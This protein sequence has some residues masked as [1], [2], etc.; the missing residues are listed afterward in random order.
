MDDNKKS[1]GTESSANESNAPTSTV[2]TTLS[3][4]KRKFRSYAQKQRQEEQEQEKSEPQKDGDELEKVKS[5]PQK[6]EKAKEEPVA[7]VAVAVEAK[8]APKTRG[9][10]S[11]KQKQQEQLQQQQ[12]QAIAEKAIEIE[13]KTSDDDHEDNEENEDDGGGGGDDDG[14]GEKGATSIATRIKSMRRRS[15]RVS[16][17]TNYYAEMDKGAKEDLVEADEH[18]MDIDADVAKINQ[19]ENND[20]HDQEEDVVNEEDQSHDISESDEMMSEEEDDDDDED[21]SESESEGDQQVASSSL[22][23]KTKAG[24]VLKHGKELKSSLKKVPTKS[25]KDVLASPSV[26]KKAQFSRD[27]TTSAAQNTAMNKECAVSE[28]PSSSG[29]GAGGGEDACFLNPT[30]AAF[31]FGNLFYCNFCGFSANNT[32]KILHHLFIHVFKCNACSHFTYTKYD[33][34]KHI[35]KHHRPNK[36]L[37]IKRLVLEVTSNDWYFLCSENEPHS[38]NSASSQPN[39]SSAASTANNSLNEAPS[40]SA[41][42][43]EAAE[44]TQQQQPKQVKTAPQNVVANKNNTPGGG[45]TGRKPVVN[46]F[47]TQKQ[48]KQPEKLTPVIQSN[49]ALTGALSSQAPVTQVAAVDDEAKGDEAKGDAGGSS[50]LQKLMQKE[51]TAKVV[52]SVNNNSPG[53]L[54]M[55]SAQSSNGSAVCTTPKITPVN[56]TGAGAIATRRASASA[57]ATSGGTAATSAVNQKL[58]VFIE[59]ANASVSGGGGGALE[60]ATTTRTRKASLSVDTSASTPTKAAK[61]LKKCN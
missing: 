27:S 58:M 1:S 39:S 31:N 55:V 3:A 17:R 7:E 16:N 14:E 25:L 38:L 34:M 12:Q 48:Q 44:I 11:T 5:E 37:K 43:S 40:A 28:L 18:Q 45:T 42:L 35:Y 20:E 41:Q 56:S 23:Q 21:L 46:Y 61:K 22:R 30:L 51:V 50:H 47:L 54:K 10:K 32:N 49:K 26:V 36:E 33:L 6:E 53:A 15:N 2:T 19:S 60:G 59:S 8:P 9:R 24:K 4:P 57:V 13:K 52:P 29:A